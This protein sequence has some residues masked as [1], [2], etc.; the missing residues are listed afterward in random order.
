MKPLAC[1][2]CLRSF[3]NKSDFKR[4]MATIHEKTQYPCRCA[5]V[6]NRKDS[7]VR[8]QRTCRKQRDSQPQ[9]ESYIRISLTSRT[10]IAPSLSWF[11]AAIPS[12]S[13]ANDA[14]LQYLKQ[15]NLIA[16]PIFPEMQRLQNNMDNSLHL[17]D[18]GDD[19]RVRQYV[20]LQNRFSAYK[21]QLN[22]VPDA[23]IL[24]QSQRTQMRT[25]FLAEHLQAV[26][27]LARELR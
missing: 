24:N 3:S 13:G 23:T 15:Q 9:L 17:S 18:L 10:S 1:S 4:H 2:V 16:P 22:L 14:L 6:F 12:Q 11:K 7:Y 19:D 20:Q 25:N 5:K 8:H 26:P 27:T 21:Q